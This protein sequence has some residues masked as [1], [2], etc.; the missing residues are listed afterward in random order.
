MQ[1]VS[2]LKSETV[3]ARN[4]LLI[5]G[6]IFVAFNLRPSITAVGPLIGSIRTDTGMSNSVAGLITTLPLLAF[7]FLSPLAPK[8]AQK[9]GKEMTIFLALIFLGVGLV[10]RSS[11]MVFTLFL[12][13]A[14][15]G[16]G[17][18]FCNVILPGIVKQSFPG[19]VG[20][21]TGIYTV[22]MGTFAGI[23]PGI[24][25]PLANKLHMGW[26]GSLSVWIVLMGVALIVWFPQ[27][28]KSEFSAR[29]KVFSTKKT[30]MLSSP[31]AWR[32][33]LFMGLQSLIYFCFITWLPEMLYS[34]GISAATAGW[35]VSILQF[36]GIPAN[37]IIPVIAD[38]LSNQKSLAIGIGA[39][40]LIGILG[41]LIGGNII[42][43]TFSIMCIGIGTGA[44]ISL[45]LTL[46]GLR[47]VNA[48]Q[49]ANLSGMAQ[50]IGYFLAALGPF[51]LGF[52]FD[53]LHSWTVPLLLLILVT[54]I[55]TVVGYGAGRN[56]YVL[57]TRDNSNT[58]NL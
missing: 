30:S 52:L 41:L 15:V 21:M 47:V 51:F 34:Q 27:V 57:E 45:A 25:V 58:V 48:E 33:T 39:L 29:T 13:T 16:L 46:I 14:I 8:L 18:A 38:R 7:A 31:L 1:K 54:F 28:R 10:I 43:I 19:K 26:Q 32:V 12:G 11:G 23:A 55:M 35:M 3:T 37:F 36:S 17:I 4:T 53:I 44:A 49:A 2:L 50:S 20:L 40:C 9:I 42:L 5:F 24:S 22:S 56:Q 6:I